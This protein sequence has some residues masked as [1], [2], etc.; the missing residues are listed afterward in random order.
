MDKN[1]KKPITLQEKQEWFDKHKKEILQWEYNSLSE[2]YRNIFCSEVEE[3][4]YRSKRQ[5]TF[6]KA[7]RPLNQGIEKRI[8]KKGYSQHE[9]K[10]I[11]NEKI[12][13]PKTFDEIWAEE[14][15]QKILSEWQTKVK[16]DYA[17]C[18]EI[19]DTIFLKETLDSIR[20]NE[21]ESQIFLL[22][23]NKKIIKTYLITGKEQQVAVR[24]DVLKTI[25]NEA[26]E[27]K[28]DIYNV[29]NH[30]WHLVANPSEA[31]I[32]AK[33]KYKELAKENDIMLIDFAIVT[34]FDYYSAKE[35]GEL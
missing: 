32:I 15:E 29:H 13:F 19:V 7:M 22:I 31:D 11:I 30:P 25:L 4:L 10:E 12:M 33:D 5:K 26:I 24:E 28:C 8:M 27:Q 16:L 1:E 34:Q 18:N 2:I 35:K 9:I 14:K 17:G 21:Y 23:N 20:Y 3:Y 6:K